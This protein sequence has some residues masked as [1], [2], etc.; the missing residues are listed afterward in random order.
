MIEAWTC[1]VIDATT[2]DCT[3][4]ASSTLTVY[5]STTTQ[6]I[7]TGSETL[8]IGSI[9]IFFLSFLSWRYIFRLSR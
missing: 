3:V 9:I 4:T 5:T 2:T 7:L 6:D 1:I 8:F